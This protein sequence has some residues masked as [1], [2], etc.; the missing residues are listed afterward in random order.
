VRFAALR[1]ARVYRDH[2][3]DHERSI[4]WFRNAANR[5]GCDAPTEIGALRELIEVYTHRMREPARALPD[6][7]RLASKHGGTTSG[8]WARKQIADIKKE[9]P[10]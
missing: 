6:L 4:S 10:S 8:E 3:N 2:L 5:T 1:L 7:A 9:M